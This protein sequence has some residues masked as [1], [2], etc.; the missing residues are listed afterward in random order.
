MDTNNND[1]IRFEVYVN[2]QKYY[3]AEKVCNT[4]IDLIQLMS[5]FRTTLKSF[6]LADLS[7]FKSSQNSLF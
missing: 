1:V 3:I 4:D 7:R 2:G 5:A 6:R